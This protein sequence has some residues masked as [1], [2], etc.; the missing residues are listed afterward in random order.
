MRLRS[1][2]VAILGA[3]G[4]PTVSSSESR[5]FCFHRFFMRWSALA[6][7]APQTCSASASARPSQ[8]AMSGATSRFRARSSRSACARPR[9]DVDVLGVREA[10]E[11][12]ARMGER[13][14]GDPLAERGLE[15]TTDRV[16]VHHAGVREEH[17]RPADQRERGGVVGDEDRSVPVLTLDRVGVGEAERAAERA[18]PRASH[19]RRLR[20]AGRHRAVGDEVVE[21]RA[22]VGVEQPAAVRQRRAG[23][24]Q[25][26]DQPA[27][28]RCP[29]TRSRRRAGAAARSR[30]VRGGS[31][32]TRGLRSASTACNRG[33]RIET[34]PSWSRE[35]RVQQ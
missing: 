5:L 14:V 16:A 24:D 26:G 21:A 4:W 32:G 6:A 33:V 18:G 13:Y 3:G 23:R 27:G 25:V 7:P 2:G 30:R 8:D 20:R 11:P 22:L 35:R 19:A 15:R 9:R 29:G 17:V 10:G 34:R 31:N 12:A 28:T 1:R